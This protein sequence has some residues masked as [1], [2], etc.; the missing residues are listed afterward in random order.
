LELEPTKVAVTDLLVDKVMMQFPV[1]VHPAP[2]Q[3][4]NENPVDGVART[5]IVLP[6]GNGNVQELLQVIPPDVLTTV[7]LPFVA[8]VSK[9]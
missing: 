3:P 7:P 9:A 4:A 5:V 6:R 1:P 2:L 8:M